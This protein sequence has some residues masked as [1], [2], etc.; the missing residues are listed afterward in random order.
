MGRYA[1][2][3]APSCLTNSMCLLRVVNAHAAQA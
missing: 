1:F 3:H 2:F